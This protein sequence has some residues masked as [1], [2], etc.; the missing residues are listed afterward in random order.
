MTALTTRTARSR[1]PRA[2]RPFAFCALACA[3]AAASCARAQGGAEQTHAYALN[4]VR[5]SGADDC[6]ASSVL[7][8]RIEQI[9]GPVFRAP[10]A[11]DRALEGLIERD[12]A[13]ARFTVNVRMT[14]RTGAVIGER[15]FEREAAECGAMTDSILLVVALM[16]D[17]SAG[18]RG[19]PPELLGLLADGQEPGAALLADLA[20]ERAERERAAASAPAPAPPVTPAPAARRTPPPPRSPD[21]TA[22]ATRPALR[23]G[24]ELALTGALSAWLQPSAAPGA[25][26][27]ARVTTPWSFALDL[28]ASYWLPSEVALARPTA[29]GDGVEFHAASATLALCLVLAQLSAGTAVNACAGAALT[30]RWT[31]TDALGGRAQSAGPWLGPVLAAELRHAFTSRWFALIGASALG[32]FPRDTFFYANELGR[33]EQLFEP[34]AIAALVSAGI[35]ARL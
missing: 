6:I 10:D 7:A 16:I 20:R 31:S 23:F 34:A 13:H 17:P 28:G 25:G 21:P 11:A 8:Q 12:L 2:A 4:W 5:G 15:R 33:G 30:T 27:G 32:M 19:L 29:T 24:L 1:T 3:A 14:D 26:L 9:L 35:G 22:T 18:E